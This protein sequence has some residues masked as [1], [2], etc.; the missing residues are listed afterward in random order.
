MSIARYCL[1]LFLALACT[2]PSGDDPGTTEPET[3]PAETAVDLSKYVIV[4]AADAEAE[5]G[6]DLAAAVRENVK[7]KTGKELA[8]IT[9][10]T[11][12]TDFEI[13]IGKTSRAASRAYYAGK[14]GIFDY[15]LRVSGG[16]VLIAGGGCWA[17][18]K[19]NALMKVNKLVDGLEKKGS[20]YGEMLFPREAGANLRLLD[21]N[22][23]QYNKT[24]VPA[25]WQA[26]GADCTN[27]VRCIGFA[28]L[29]LA[30]L[31]DAVCFQEYSKD[32]DAL[33]RPRLEGKGYK[34]A[35]T[36]GTDWD[37]T[38]ILYN[39][40]TLTLDHVE[41]L[42]YT[43]STYCD[44]GSKSYTAAVFTLKSAGKQFALIGTHLWWKSESALAGSNAAREDQ[45]GR[46]LACAQRLSDD[47]KCP[48]FVTGDM[49]CTL[50]SNAMK[51]LT[52]AGMKPLFDIATVHGDKRNGYHSCS[53]EGFSR[54]SSKSDDGFGCIDQFLLYNQGSAEVKTFWRIEPYFTVELTDHYPNYTDIVI[55]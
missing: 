31:P 8:V 26:A 36:P 55:Q 22:V 33:L 12:E 16:K 47:Y 44:G 20:V 30:Y 48:V 24:T 50:L 10:A 41:Y 18:E 13:L 38:P 52:G 54:A 17:M 53:S 14:P 23:W 7:A 1:I 21:D 9:D 46:I 11:P 4:Y 5:E 39:N 2:K 45:A 42:R 19:A 15:L 37:Y 49:N 27:A 32:M 40:K 35:Y 43:P 51:V 6:T 25:A 34:L 3:P 29:V 28:G